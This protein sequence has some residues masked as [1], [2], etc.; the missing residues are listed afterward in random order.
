MLRRLSWLMLLCILV[1]GCAA[2]EDAEKPGG[3]LAAAFARPWEATLQAE[4]SAV[5][6]LDEVR[7]GE[8]NSLLKHVGLR[9]RRETDGGVKLSGLT[10]LVDGEPALDAVLRESGDTAAAFLPGCSEGYAASAGDP[11]A[12]IFGA[13]SVPDTEALGL[14][15]LGTLREADTWTDALLAADGLLSVKNE[16]QKVGNYGTAVTRH[17]LTAAS[18]E[19]QAFGERILAACPDGWLKKKLTGAVFRGKQSL[20]MLCDADGTA[21]KVSYSGRIVFNGGDE[22][23]VTFTWRRKRDGDE[24]DSLTLKTPGADGKNRTNLVLKRTVKDG[25]DGAHTE[26]EFT[27]DRKLDRDRTLTEGTL[28]LTVGSQV[29]GTVK[30]TASVTGGETKKTALTLKPD[31][32]VGG[33]ALLSGSLAWEYREDGHVTSAWTVTGTVRPLAETVWE[34]PG[35]A[36]M[37]EQLSVEELGQVRARAVGAAAR[38]LIPRLV[39]LPEADTGYLRRELENWDEIVSAARAAL[40]E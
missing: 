19:A 38:A 22:R 8:L 1:T 2:G 34:L 3:A 10:L 20:S 18:D 4:A 17:A 9:L 23:N 14:E 31:L 24:M 27:L 40:G 30:L 6:P 21:L 35:S 29:T 32:S 39:L 5:M 16:R 33:A 15:A 25:P 26:A 28:K 13:D 36:V 11:L 7:T 12:M 37:L